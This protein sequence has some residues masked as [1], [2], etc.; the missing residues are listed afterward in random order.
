MKQF[1]NQQVKTMAWMKTLAPVLLNTGALRLL[2][3]VQG[4]QDQLP[5]EFVAEMAYLQRNKDFLLVGFAELDSFDESATETRNSGNFGDKPMIVLTAGKFVDLPSIPKK[6]FEQFQQ[7]WIHELQPQ[8]ATLSTRGK[9][10]IV[11][12]STH[13]IPMEQPQAV[14]D[15]IR[16]VVKET[17]RTP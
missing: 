8:L 1:M 7:T 17:T 16:E 5:P 10:V 4:G 2:Q 3:H 13:M 15:A 9:Q 11:S 14:V 6:D 12:N